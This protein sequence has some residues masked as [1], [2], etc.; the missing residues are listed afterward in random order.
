MAG[1]EDKAVAVG[2]AGGVGVVRER[3]AVKHGA[4]LSTAERETEVAGVAF[5]DGINGEAT[6]LI[7]GLGE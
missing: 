1:R 6:G 4:D 5:M 3:V 2:P 7:G